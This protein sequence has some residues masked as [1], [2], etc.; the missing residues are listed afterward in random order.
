MGGARWKQFWEIFGEGFGGEKMIVT[1]SVEAELDS[2]SK[3]TTSKVMAH[4]EDRVITLGEKLHS[5]TY[6]VFS[7][8]L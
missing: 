1:C 8:A 4:Q 3:Y 2:A 5:S 6:S 7:Q